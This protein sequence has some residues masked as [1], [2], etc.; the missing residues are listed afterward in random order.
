MSW[1]GLIDLYTWHKPCTKWR[2]M[3]NYQSPLIFPLK[4]TLLISLTLLLLYLLLPNTTILITLS[5]RHCRKA[6]LTP[7]PQKTFQHPLKSGKSIT[8]S[9]S[10]SNNLHHSISSIGTPTNILDR[11]DWEGMQCYF[12]W[13]YINNQETLIILQDPQVLAQLITEWQE[14]P[15][16]L[17][18]E[19]SGSNPQRAKLCLELDSNLI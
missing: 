19:R 18:P 1:Q 11:R 9:T 5:L 4:Q 3:L 6:L 7:L 14:R 16:Q 12:P 13:T 15:M 10:A 17:L 2:Y 8:I